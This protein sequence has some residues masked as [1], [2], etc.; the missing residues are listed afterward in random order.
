MK[1]MYVLCFAMLLLQPVV[2]VCFPLNAFGK[3]PWGINVYNSADV[4]EKMNVS[5]AGVDL[6]KYGYVEVYQYALVNTDTLY[7]LGATESSEKSV[8]IL[9]SISLNTGK[10]TIV[11]QY[12]RW[13]VWSLPKA[14]F[15]IFFLQNLQPSRPFVML[16]YTD[17]NISRHSEETEVYLEIFRVDSEDNY[18]LIRQEKIAEKNILHSGLSSDHQYK[19]R[20]IQVDDVP[21][22]PSPAKA[23]FPTM[24]FSDANGDGYT[25]ILIWKRRYISRETKDTGRGPFALEQEELYVMYFVPEE[26]TFSV[27]TPLESKRWKD[28]GEVLF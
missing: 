13:L 16:I 2:L 7:I 27:L 11:K 12:S 14:K 24:F 3:S 19:F 15:N 10:I 6:S 8:P 1:K 25:D 23:E 5:V 28:L 17:G 21:E 20:Y 22:D 18:A 9:S 4:D 26:I